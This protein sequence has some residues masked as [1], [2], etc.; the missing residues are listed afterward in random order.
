MEIILD[1]IYIYV[2]VFTVYFLALSIR[3]LKDKKLKKQKELEKYEINNNFCI[4]VYSHNDSTTLQNLIKQLRAQNYPPEAYTV[5]VILDNCTDNSEQ[6]VTSSFVKPLIIKNQGT[7]GKDQAISILLEKLSSNAEI[8]TAYVFLDANRY[9]EADFLYSINNA[10]IKSPVLCG[11]TVLMCA[12][13]N[14][15]QQIKI[16]YQKYYNNFLQKARSL[17]GLAVTLDS[18][19]FVIRQDLMEKIGCIDFRNINS[20]LKYSLLLSKIGCKCY[21]NPNIKTYID[22]DKFNLRIPSITTRL[23]LF[24]S[25]LGSLISTNYTFT[26]H[27][28]S[29]L[30]PNIWL[31]IICYVYLLSFSYSCS[32][33]ISFS[34]VVLSFALLVF[35]FAIS[36]MNSKLK[37]KEYLYLM[38]YPIY[39]FFHIL[40]NLPLIR[41]IR[42]KFSGDVNDENIQKMD[43][44]IVVSDAKNRCITC[45]LQL[46]SENGLA[47]V[48]LI[49]KKNKFVTS[50]H[51][52]MVDAIKELTSKADEHEFTLK[53][54]QCCKYFTP[55]IDGS[56]NMVKGF[57]NGNYPAYSENKPIPTLLWNS[58][59]NFDRCESKSI[60]D[61]II[62]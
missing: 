2:A 33:M 11:E 50:E 17:A 49:S 16:T 4:I 14:L 35:G 53:I 46:I 32:M 61:K 13:P 27:S 9:I 59:P 15:V 29:L 5:Y 38:I 19:I 60:L 31:L 36:L 23:N 18:N 42:R 44:N 56:T 45:S 52:R 21:F 7:I 39:S 8:Y 54:C 51:L 30:A 37:S 43:V 58:C 24:K 3:N 40:R 34:G 55:N 25:C 22:V 26:E 28:L 6:I 62:G 48:K 47:K 20:E 12:K 10:L 41:A 1:I 57:C